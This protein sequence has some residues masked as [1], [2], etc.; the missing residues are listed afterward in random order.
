MDCTLQ[1]AVK[2]IGGATLNE[3]N[4]IS[5]NGGDGISFQNGAMQVP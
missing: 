3:R 4:V 1:V 5:S 2:T